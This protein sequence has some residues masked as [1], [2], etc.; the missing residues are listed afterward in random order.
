MMPWASLNCS[1]QVLCS[2]QETLNETK[3]KPGLGDMTKIRGHDGRKGF[4]LLIIELERRWVSAQWTRSWTG[5]RHRQLSALREEHKH[6]SEE[7]SWWCASYIEMLA[8]HL[9]SFLFS[10]LQEDPTKKVRAA[11]HETHNC[12]YVC[13]SNTHS[14]HWRNQNENTFLIEGIYN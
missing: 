6:I 14:Q 8:V 4:G 11:V 5:H 7:F 10:K 13:S 9:V 3:K 2:S 12:D 1:A